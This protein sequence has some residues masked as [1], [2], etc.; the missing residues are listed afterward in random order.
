MGSGRSSDVCECLTVSNPSTASIL[1]SRIRSHNGSIVAASAATFALVT[2]A[3]AAWYGIAYWLV[4]FVLTVLHAGDAGLPPSFDRFCIIV[5]AVLMVA[6]IADTWLFP[7]ERAVDERP[8][9][10]TA[11]DI[12]LFI[13]RLTIS[14]VMNFAAWARLPSRWRG[15]AVDLLERLKEYRKLALTSLPLHLPNDRSRLRIMHVLALIQLTELRKEKGE[16]WLRISPL[17]PESLRSGLLPEDADDEMAG[18]RRATVFKDKNA[19]PSPKR[20]LPANDRN[21]L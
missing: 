8:A 18:M 6:G 16:W 1:R 9:T 11:I 5:A 19:L 15:E 2:V 12:I 20:Q 17:A 7:S 14:V 21:D 13:P 4:M 10:E 3:W